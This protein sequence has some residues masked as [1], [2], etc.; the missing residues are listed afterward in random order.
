MHDDPRAALAPPSLLA[1][2]DSVIAALLRT[3][4]M[5]AGERYALAARLVCTVRG[6][7]AAQQD[8]GR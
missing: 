4:Y 3:G 5:G 1:E 6:P 2:L 8:D 7:L